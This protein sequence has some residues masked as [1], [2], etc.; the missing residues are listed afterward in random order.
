VTIF[1][2]I[3]FVVDIVYSLLDPRVR[4]GGAAAH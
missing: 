3:N 2:V 4:L 1:I